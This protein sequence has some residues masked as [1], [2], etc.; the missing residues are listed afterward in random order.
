MIFPQRRMARGRERWPVILGLTAA[1]R[2][3]LNHKLAHTFIVHPSP[4]TQTVTLDT[5]SILQ[6]SQKSCN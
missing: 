3:V 2:K 6:T 1:S 4:S 5:S